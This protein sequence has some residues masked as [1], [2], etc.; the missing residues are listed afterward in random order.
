[1]IKR[2]GPKIEPCGTPHSRKDLSELCN[3][4][5]SVCEVGFKPFQYVTSD[6]IRI[7]LSNNY[8]VSY[9]IKSF[10]PVG[11]LEIE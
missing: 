2:I 9:S 11:Y 3:I 10:F 6:A 5:R 1:M 4:L 7:H 8:R